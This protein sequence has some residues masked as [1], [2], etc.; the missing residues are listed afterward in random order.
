MPFADHAFDVAVC[1]QGLQFFPDHGAALR[2]VHRVLAPGGRLALAL[3]CEVES[4]PGHHAL[5]RSLAEHVGPEAA[6]LM[7]AVFRLGAAELIRTL[8]EGAGFQPVRIHRETRMARFRSS[9][10]FTRFVVVGSVLGRT[11]VQVPDATLSALIDDVEAAL[12]PYVHTDGLEFP[13]EAHLVLA[14]TEQSA[15]RET[16]VCP[17]RRLNLTS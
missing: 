5:A 11:G 1:Q 7:Y 16:N 14:H 4:S 2:E 10:A 3:W 8:L 6:A 15:G 13:M 17:A 12:R 9:E